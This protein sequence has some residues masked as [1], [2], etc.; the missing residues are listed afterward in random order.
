M[1]IL[2][3]YARVHLRIVVPA[4]IRELLLRLSNSALILGFGLGYLNLDQLVLGITLSY[5]F[6][7]IGLL[8]YIKQLKRFYTR[9]DF[10]FLRKPVFH[11]MLQYGGWV[12]LAGASFTLIQHVEKLM[13][14]AYAGG[15]GTTAVF[16][17]NSRMGLMIAIPR[18][19]I[20]AISTPILAQAWKRED[21]GQIADI[22][23]KSS[24]NL[25]LVG[26][27][28]FLASGATSILSTK[29]SPTMRFTKPVNGWF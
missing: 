10:S 3:A 2:E 22:Y 1:A 27:F 11:E 7:V 26:C 19:V 23:K 28:L 29:S 5:V 16:D 17:I 21:F 20:A 8:I 14:P 15:L 6:A 24:A 25:L 12:I 4:I 13:L 18:N 9:F